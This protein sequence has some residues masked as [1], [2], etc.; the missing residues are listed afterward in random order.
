MARDVDGHEYLDLLS[1]YTALVHGNAPAIVGAASRALE[2]DTYWAAAN[3]HMLELAELLIPIGSRR[4][5]RCGSATPARRRPCTAMVAREGDGSAHGADGP[6]RV[7]RQLRRLRG[8]QPGEGTDPTPSS[9]RS[10]APAAFEAVLADQGDEIACVILEPVMGSSGV[11]PAAGLPRPGGRRGP[12]PAPCSSW[13]RSSRSASLPAVPRPWGVEPDLTTFGK[14]IGGGFP[15]GALGGR[16]ACCRS[17]IPLG[18][19]SRCRAP[20]TPTL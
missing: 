17:P 18:E 19:G 16:R 15:V 4:W 13:T 12:Q 10:V 7:P 1:N 8:R 11:V 20:S 14:L 9:P 5:S 3:E 2:G 6:V